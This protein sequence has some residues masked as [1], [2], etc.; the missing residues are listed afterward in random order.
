MENM[1]AATKIIKGNKLDVVDITQFGYRKNTTNEYVPNAYRANFGWKNTYYQAAEC[2][3]SIPENLCKKIEKWE[4]YL[5]S[6]EAAKKN[7]RG[8]YVSILST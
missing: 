6:V 3:V 8:D 2:I 7:F 1:N 4:K 5:I